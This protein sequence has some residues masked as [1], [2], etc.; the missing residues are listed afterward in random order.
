MLMILIKV[1]TCA[2]MDYRASKEIIIPRSIVLFFSRKGH[3]LS[4]VF[5]ELIRRAFSQPFEC[6]INDRP[7]AKNGI[8]AFE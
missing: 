1:Q 2:E 4:I 7:T 3:F 5:K 6:L 8:E